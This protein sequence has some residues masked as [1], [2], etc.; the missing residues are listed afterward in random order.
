MRSLRKISSRLGTCRTCW[1]SDA[2]ARS[3]ATTVPRNLPLILNRCAAAGMAVLRRQRG[4]SPQATSAV[5]V[6][7]TSARRETHEQRCRAV[8]LQADPFERTIGGQRNSGSRA[9]A[10]FAM[11]LAHAPDGASVRFAW[12]RLPQSLLTLRPWSYAHV[13]RSMGFVRRLAGNVVP[14][15][16]GPQIQSSMQSRSTSPSLPPW[17]DRLSP[18]AA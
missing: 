3:S 4:R 14:N 16:P 5:L 10:G 6:A 11:P 8:L 7:A 18:V 15:A 12:A 17:N 2:N 9:F 1:K 13:A